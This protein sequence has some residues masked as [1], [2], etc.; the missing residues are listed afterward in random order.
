[1]G[2]GEL[3]HCQTELAWLRGQLQES[4]PPDVPGGPRSE[5]NLEV[6]RPVSTD[7]KHGRIITGWGDRLFSVASWKSDKETLQRVQG[8]HMCAQLLSCPEWPPRVL[9]PSTHERLQAVLSSPLEHRVVEII[10]TC[11]SDVHPLSAVF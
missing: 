8:T 5:M 3:A 2:T 6:T 4:R 1:M 11:I 9:T 7:K 10:G